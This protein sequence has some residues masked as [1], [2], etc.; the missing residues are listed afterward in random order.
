MENARRLE[1][2]LSGPITSRPRLLQASTFHHQA[3]LA[4][5]VH[6]LIVAICILTLEPMWQVRIPVAETW[7]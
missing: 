7:P 2:E 1:V 5:L 6:G 4:K 3:G